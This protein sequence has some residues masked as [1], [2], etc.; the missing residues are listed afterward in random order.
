MVITDISRAHSK[1]MKLSKLL[2]TVLTVS[3]ETLRV[4]VRNCCM[5]FLNPVSESTNSKK[6]LT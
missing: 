1:Y 5:G 4:L 3:S 2:E 6:F